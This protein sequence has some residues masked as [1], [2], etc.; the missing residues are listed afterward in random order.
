MPVTASYAAVPQA[1]NLI[2]QQIA[3]DRRA[4]QS[5]GKPLL[6]PPATDTAGSL[7]SV[8][9]GGEEKATSASG[10][11]SHASSSSTCRL[12]VYSVHSIIGFR[13]LKISS[14]FKDI[15][16]YSTQTVQY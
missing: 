15:E 7:A 6:S 4:R 8:A 9:G 5:R 16:H 12:Q 3:D 10:A 11:K 14:P 2:K 1:R 13:V